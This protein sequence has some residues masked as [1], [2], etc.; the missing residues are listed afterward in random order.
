M[1]LTKRQVLQTGQT[2]W[3]YTRFHATPELPFSSFF[4]SLSPS[5]F[6][7]LVPLGWYFP[8]TSNETRIPNR[9]K[10]AP[11]PETLDNEMPYAAERG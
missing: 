10:T 3:L 6:L 1:D 9:K 2:Q 11:G 4:S 7:G 5:I 8:G